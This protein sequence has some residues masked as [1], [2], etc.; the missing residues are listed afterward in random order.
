[1]FLLCEQQVKTKFPQR[2]SEKKTRFLP[3]PRTCFWPRQG[4]LPVSGTRR[5]AVNAPW[6]SADRSTSP[7]P[8]GDTPKNQSAHNCSQ[9]NPPPQ[10]SLWRAKVHPAVAVKRQQ[11]RS[12]LHVRSHTRKRATEAAATMSADEIPRKPA[13]R[14]GA[15]HFFPVDMFRKCSKRWSNS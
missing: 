14:P 1:M 6:I 9:A 2:I 13:C 8:P 5:R 12:K 10:T 4:S 11:R 15:A 3:T 7:T